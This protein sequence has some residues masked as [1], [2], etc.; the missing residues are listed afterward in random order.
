MCVFFTLD[1][2]LFIFCVFLLLQPD[3]FESH[4]VIP[5]CAE[6]IGQLSVFLSPCAHSY[7]FHFPSCLLMRQ[8]Q[9]RCLLAQGLCRGNDSWRR[10]WAKLETESPVSSGLSG[11]T[12]NPSKK[13]QRLP[14]K[15]KECM[16]ESL[17][18]FG[19][20]RV[21]LQ[22][23]SVFRVTLKWIFNC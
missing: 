21:K 13:V 18:L 19:R 14:K 5:L 12:F 17:C 10:M 15:P 11:V 20:K 16:P 2:Y 1:D 3:I 8:A 22:C 4:A 23:K 7:F 9:L 6:E